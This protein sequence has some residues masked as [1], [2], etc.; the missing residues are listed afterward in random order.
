MLEVRQ[1]SKEDY[2]KLIE[3]WKK[4]DFEPVPQRKL[5]LNGVGGVMVYKDNV[6]ICA[7]FLYTTNSTIAW[8]E[9]VVA[10]KD[11]RQSDRREAIRLLISKLTD[12]AKDLNFDTVFTVVQNPFLL[13]HFKHSG[14]TS[15]KNKS[16]EM[17]KLI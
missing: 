4:E 16:T 2:Q 10:D 11:Y 6:D 13:N 15:D 7:G 1:L 8:L 12:I 17:V 3:W 5:P 14:F 9:F